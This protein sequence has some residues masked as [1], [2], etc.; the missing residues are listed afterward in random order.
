MSIPNRQ[1]GWNT[2]S[3]LLWNISKQVERLI[4]V[5]YNSFV[6]RPVGNTLIVDS[7]YGDDV[8]AA[9]DKYALSFKTISEALANTKAGD[10]VIVNAG[11]YNESIVMPDN[12]SLTGTGAQAV[13]IQKLNVTENTTLLTMGINC[14]VENATFNLSS[15]GNFDLIGVDFPSGTSINAKL[16]NSIWTITSTSTDTPSVIGARSAGTSATTYSSANSIQ[17]STLNV[18]SSSNGTSRG[19]LVSG[20]NRFSVRDIVVFARGTGSDIVGVEVTNAS[21]VAE[22]KTSTVSGTLYDVNRILGTLIIGATDLLN[23]NPNGNSFT[24]TQAPA[25]IFYGIVNGLGTNRRYYLLP[26][27]NVTGNITNVAKTN[28]YDPT[29]GFPIPFTQPS[30]IIDTILTFTATLGVGEA[31]TFNVYKNN[32]TSPSLTLTLSHGEGFTKS[33]STQSLSLSATDTIITTLETTGDPANDGA[34]SVSVGY[35]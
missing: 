26:G 13:I 6:R 20:A 30:T 27:S 14:R 18:I 2:Q 7:V 35:Y 12:V 10:L 17:R 9:S 31:I 1:I 34:F 16:R 32:Q 28:P 29:L 11:I 3:N 19:I 5:T 21:A 23:N 15:S 4:G 24:P 25:S 33:L 8:K 22:I